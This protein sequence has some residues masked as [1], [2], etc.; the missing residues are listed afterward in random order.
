MRQVLVKLAAYLIACEQNQPPNTKRQQ[1]YEERGIEQESET[2][3]EALC[4]IGMAFAQEEQEGENDTEQGNGRE[5]Y[6]D[7]SRA[8]PQAQETNR[9]DDAE[10]TECNLGNC[11]EI[12]R[13]V[14]RRLRVHQD[15][16]NAARVPTDRS[17][18]RDAPKHDARRCDE[19]RNGSGDDRSRRAIGGCGHIR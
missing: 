6:C 14:G 2:R 18:I 11:E 3:F 13:R 9:R 19:E 4:A 7:F 10:Q 8:F 5:E 1:D 15:L 17:Q 16:V 12:K